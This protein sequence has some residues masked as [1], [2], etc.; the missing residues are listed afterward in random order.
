MGEEKTAKSD[1]AMPIIDMRLRILRAATSLMTEKGI[2]ET[3]LKDIAQKAGI[4]KGTLYYYYSAKEDIIYDIAN[5]NLK[6]VTDGLMVMLDDADSNVSAEEIIKSLFEN[7]LDAQTRGK[8][9][10]YLLN[11]IA[12]TNNALAEKFEMCYNDWRKTL[13]RGLDKVMPASK[14]D[15]VALSH[16][17]LATIDGL[18]IQKMCGVKNIPVDEI[19]KLLIKT[20]TN[21]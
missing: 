6:Q 15:H 3:T 14:G 13:E 8:L 17:I 10:I 4:S 5:K 19:V 21:N 12:T 11:N 9:H 20:K 1:D 7:I 16:L 2:K 18:I